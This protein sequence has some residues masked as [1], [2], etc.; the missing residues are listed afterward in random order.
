MPSLSLLATVVALVCLTHCILA[1]GA[2][3]NALMC[4]SVACEFNLD[5][6]IAHQGCN[7]IIICREQCY[8]SAADK[9]AE[10]SCL[11]ACVATQSATA[12]TLYGQLNDCYESLCT[13][14]YQQE[15]CRG[16]LTQ[17]NCE[18]QE[19]CT[20][21]T[22]TDP[23]QKC[24]FGDYDAPVFTSCELGITRPTRE[25]GAK[26]AV[27]WSEIV[28][29]DASEVTVTQIEGP[30]SGS[31]FALGTT[32]I[33]FQAVDSWG[34]T[35]F[36][37]FT[38]TVVDPWLPVI[39]SCPS[40]ITKNPTVAEI[41]YINGTPQVSVT[42]IQPLVS[43]NVAAEFVDLSPSTNT[44]LFAIGTHPVQY[45]ARDSSGNE[46][47][48][49]FFVSIVPTALSYFTV[50]AQS[51]IPD[52]KEGGSFVAGVPLNACAQRCLD[53][54]NCKAF[55]ADRAG[56]GSCFISHKT[57]SESSTF[58]DDFGYNYYERQAF[59]LLECPYAEI[60]ACGDISAFVDAPELG[61]NNTVA[62]Y[63]QCVSS[64]SAGCLDTTLLSNIE[65]MIQEANAS[66]NSLTIE[67]TYPNAT[68]LSCDGNFTSLQ[69]CQAC[70]SQAYEQA[71]EPCQL[72]YHK[73]QECID[74]RAGLMLPCSTACLDARPYNGVQG[75]GT[76][77]EAPVAPTPSGY[78]DFTL[79]A[80]YTGVSLA[81]FD[82]VSQV[83]AL[84]A[85]TTAFRFPVKDVYMAP[86]TAIVNGFSV[87]F[88]TR[89]P[90]SY[91]LPSLAIGASRRRD[92]VQTA[93][94]AE[95]L[96]DSATIVAVLLACKNLLLEQNPETFMNLTL[97]LVDSTIA[98]PQDVQDLINAQSTTT[99]TDP[100]TGPT[101]TATVTS[102]TTPNA[103]FTSTPFQGSSGQGDNDTSSP[104]VI[105]IGIV[106]ALLFIIIVIVLVKAI[107]RKRANSRYPKPANA[108]A[109]RRS[110]F[111]APGVGFTQM[112]D[113]AQQAK[114][115]PPPTRVAG[116]TFDGIQIPDIVPKS[117]SNIPSAAASVAPQVPAPTNGAAATPSPGSSRKPTIPSTMPSMA[118]QRPQQPDPFAR[119]PAPGGALPPLGRA[120]SPRSPKQLPKISKPATPSRSKVSPA[121][122]APEGSAVK[123]F[124]PLP[125]VGQPLAEAAAAP[126]SPTSPT[127]P[128]TRSPAPS[129]S[130]VASHRSSRATSAASARNLPPVA[131]LPNA[132]PAADGDGDAD[133][134]E[135]Q[136]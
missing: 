15:L 113:E 81:A 64:V 23:D 77:V 27:S 20:F 129:S 68:S 18:A 25:T 84:L 100:G 21:Q 73:K 112:Q 44:Q 74:S 50:T 65:L 116:G 117:T 56:I 114:R 76:G 103:T 126:S 7:N 70:C 67:E 37:N 43:D 132:I 131:S 32:A 109:P 101:T 111:G 19:G 1:A 54:S 57:S 105:A 97:Q 2:D 58:T 108:R 107:K 106:G 8:V 42:W 133:A 104:A 17:V 85:L 52:G 61:C 55:S 127:T 93:E 80:G 95:E 3:S 134:M 16:Y 6:C 31:E 94:L 40:N 46:A 96:E 48:C 86:A 49:K 136:A 13:E 75:L 34:N 22:H 41:V 83:D 53:D 92:V 121:A 125:K 39:S 45:I 87:E 90:Y 119:A 28:A 115:K 33:S 51:Y 123:T 10:V 59:S 118:P 91:A 89:L 26:Q 12:V 4:Q 11:D 63:A 29:V 38:V 24:I 88:Q 102:T 128:T 124:P 62:T 35:E 78:V 110:I 66:C 69:K 130:P 79:V 71:I 30:S 98:V 99:T 5:N 72:L 60:D 9:F 14:V 120:K 36:C 135:S 82:A 122:F 47:E